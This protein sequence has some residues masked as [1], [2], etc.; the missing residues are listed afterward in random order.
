MTKVEEELVFLLDW[1]NRY[2]V[3]MAAG[4]LGGSV[5]SAVGFILWYRRVQRYQD[6][7]LRRQ[8]TEEPETR[9]GP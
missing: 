2:M 8:A 6:I 9:R 3:A 4:L 5:L 1:K 7:L